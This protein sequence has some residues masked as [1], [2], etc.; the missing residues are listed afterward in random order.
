MEKT[1][2]RAHKESDFYRSI[3]YDIKQVLV[4][5]AE[6]FDNDLAE[7][8]PY[9]RGVKQALYVISDTINSRLSKSSYLR[10]PEF[11]DQLEDSKPVFTII[12]GGLS[13][14]EK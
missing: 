14:K 12:K 4:P 6:A 2:E 8:T 10:C 5:A 1:L 7:D 9:N 3:L 13:K 11:K